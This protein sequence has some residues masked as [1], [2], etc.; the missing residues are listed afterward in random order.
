MSFI[1]MKSMSPP[2]PICIRGNQLAVSKNVRTLLGCGMKYNSL[3]RLITLKGELE[4]CTLYYHIP[5]NERQYNALATNIL[6]KYSDEE[7][8][9]VFGDCLIRFNNIKLKKSCSKTI[10][11][12]YSSMSGYDIYGERVLPKP[13]RPKT[14]RNFFLSK[15]HREYKKNND[16]YNF[17][18]CNEQANRL[19]KNMSQK[20]RL[21]FEA[22]KEQD[23]MRYE[24]EM[25]DY[26]KAYPPS[27]QKPPGM[28]ALFVMDG[29][30]RSNWKS[31]SQKDKKSYA[32]RRSKL[33]S[34]LD[35]D[36]NAWKQELIQRGLNPQDFQ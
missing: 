22:M 16:H 29:N 9:K 34:K 24:R 8:V 18:E 26:N 20:D 3:I 6:E 33:L 17:K 31:V 27:P 13:K 1:L 11:S 2:I 19:W 36:R 4:S 14:A 5:N 32:E 15:F 10:F 35:T 23:R 25:T 21:E 7:G 12:C 30:D 28:I